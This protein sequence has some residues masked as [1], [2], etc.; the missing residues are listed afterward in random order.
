MTHR[1][2]ALGVAAGGLAA[3]TVSLAARK[4]GEFDLPTLLAIGR[5]LW[6]TGVIPRVDD[7]SYLHGTIRYVEALSAAAFFAAFHLGGALGLQA[8]GALA[9]SCIALAL[10][11]LTRPFGPVAFVA[12][13]VAMAAM[14][15]FL[16]VRSSMLSF[17]LLGLTLLALDTHRRAP[18]TARGRRALGAVAVLQLVWANTHGSAPLGLLVAGAY[19]L[20]RAAAR[21]AGGRAPALLP[22]TDATD[23]RATGVATVVAAA[24]SCVNPAGARLLLGPFRFHENLAAFSEWAR[25]SWAFYAGHEPIAAAM[26]AAALAAIALG[27]DCETGR[28]VPAV[29][30]LALAVL[31]LVFAAAAVRLVPLGVV[32]VAPWLARR[33]GGYVRPPM[34]VICAGTGLLSALPV[35][36]MSPLP[37]GVGF[38]TSHLPEGAALWAEIHRPEGHLWNPSPFGGYLS[39]RLYPGQ[40]ILM[41]GRNV[42]AH[43]SADV[44]LVDASE[45]DPAAFAEL[46]H[47]YDLQWAV[48]RSFE[49][50]DFGAPLAG[51][52]DWAMV[53]FDDVSAV[54]VKRGGADDR[55]AVEGYRVLRHLAGAGKVL[56]MAA[57]GR[58]AEELAHDGALAVQQAPASARAAFFE[59]CGAIAVRDGRRFR[60]A[61]DHLAAL[62]PGHPAL[63]V[64]FAAWR[65]VNASPAPDS[66]PGP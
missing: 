7:L 57:A 42:L 24:A 4:L 47:R 41:D 14:S 40:R 51:S 35:L 12:V 45:R 44:A 66:P 17:P 20:H 8:L 18:G 27:R 23:L 13:A 11:G 60:L 28:R 2:L 22:G 48:T 1:R 56:S 50:T 52:R 53:W 6:R 33:W 62:A 3:F 16:V 19:F 26:F 32:L 54:Y 31:G 10:W 65:D 25:P 49:G 39:W 38:D 61:V 37:L 58:H 59:A 34:Q 21:L 43:E 64:L 46:V 29:F 30:D 55:F 15:N 63:S 5:D 9:A 36:V